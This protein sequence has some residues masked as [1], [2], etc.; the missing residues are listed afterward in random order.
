LTKYALCYSVFYW[1]L[2]S[3]HPHSPTLCPYTTL[4]RSVVLLP[5]DPLRA[6]WIAENFLQDPQCYNQVRGMYGYTGT[7]NGHRVSVQGTGIDRKSTRLNSSHVS[8]SYAV[9]CLKNKQHANATQGG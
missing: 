5:G 1:F 8:S 7:W 2:R 6:T 9:F 4:F 3:L